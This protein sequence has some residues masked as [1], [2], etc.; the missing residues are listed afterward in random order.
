MMKNFIKGVLFITFPIWGTIHICS[1]ILHDIFKEVSDWV[2][3]H[4]QDK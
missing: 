2:D 4:F 1:M 3:E